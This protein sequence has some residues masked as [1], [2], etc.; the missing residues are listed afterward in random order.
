MSHPG[1]TA[2]DRHKVVIIGSGFGGLTAAKKLK[3]A[4]VDVKLIAKT[5]HHLFQP[6]LYQVATGIIPSGEIA[7]PTRMILRK[8]KN[9]QVLLGDVTHIDLANQ[10]VKSELLGH[11][12]VTPYDTL[13]VA[14]G[15]GQSYF[16]NDHFAE[17]APGMKSIDDALE[18]RARILSAFEQAERSSDP[19]RREKLLTFTVVGAGPTGV[20][21]AGQIAELADHTL[22]GAFRHID[23]TTARVI[24]LD[25]APAVLPPMGE[26][27]GKKAQ[28]RLEKMGVDIQLGAMVTDVD[29]NGITVKDSDGTIRRIESATKVWSAGVAASPLGRD[30][31]EQSE[32]EVDRA[33][34]VLVQPDLTLPGHPNVFVVGDMAHVEGVPG[35][36]Q[37]AIQGGRY[38]ANAV[39]AELKGADPSQREP[40]QYFDKGSMATVS[41]FSAVAKIGPLEF[42]GFIAWL[43]WL[44][45]H[46]V[47][48]VGF[49]R[50]LTTLL[51]W[52]VTFLSTQ[53]GN[54]T[55]TEQQAYARTRIEELEEIAAGVRD[56]E[57]VAG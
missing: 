55:I 40:F 31:A 56:T 19:A 50:K 22:K 3:R 38:A 24:L 21:M 54:L 42:G 4:D 29:R 34:R 18:L 52:T 5:T 46:L 39:R 25:A 28:A 15:A 48:L 26:K 30:L 41:R 9:C 8:Q 17:W 6:L 2:S 49:R 14:A 57:K 45:L 37:G 32:A 36:A 23:S 33:G 43:A 53:R 44:V 51:H 11:T 20:E 27:L 16:G 1:A 35:Q 12:Y 47:Y 10:T 13:I 7:P